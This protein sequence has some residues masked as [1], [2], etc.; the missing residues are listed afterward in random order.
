MVCAKHGAAVPTMS[1]AT[2]AQERRRWLINKMGLQVDTIT[3]VGVAGLRGFVLRT[4]VEQAD[5]HVFGGLII[6]TDAREVIVIRAG[7]LEDGA[8]DVF[9]IGIGVARARQ[10]EEPA[11]ETLAEVELDRGVGE[12]LARDGFGGVDVP[13]AADGQGRAVVRGPA[14]LE[15]EKQA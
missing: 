12:I 11:V 15:R 8:G 6:G 5:I 3:C 4:L 2:R 9:V 7:G 14:A 10:E 13:V 1:S